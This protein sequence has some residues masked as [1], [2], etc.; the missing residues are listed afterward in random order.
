MNK[1]FVLLTMILTGI[2]LALAGCGGGGGGSAA[3]ATLSTGN[4]SLV[5]TATV[6]GMIQLPGQT[7]HGNIVVTLSR[8]EGAQVAAIAR[9]ISGEIAADPQ[10]LASPNRDLGIYAGVTD[11]AGRYSIPGVPE[12]DYLLSAKKG[13]AYVGGQKSLSVSALLS[14]VDAGTVLL[15][16]TGSI[17]G[18]VAFNPP[19]ANMAGVLC[20]IEGTSFL[21]VT[22]ATGKYTISSVPLLDA[23]Y[24]IGFSKTGFVPATIGPVA[25]PTSA[26][27]D[28]VTAPTVTLGFTAFQSGAGNV[29]V[30]VAGGQ[31]YLQSAQLTFNLAVA[32]GVEAPIYMIWSQQ[33]YLS[34]A[35]GRAPER[36]A[37]STEP[38]AATKTFTLPAEG[39]YTFYLMLIYADGRQ[40]NLTIPNQIYYDRTAPVLSPV[41]YGPSQPN[42]SGGVPGALH[43]RAIQA[44]L[45]AYDYVSG[46]NAM[47]IS[48]D[49]FATGTYE[50]YA[51]YKGLTLPS[52]S[53]TT[54]IGI[55]V[56]DRAGNVASATLPAP[57][58]GLNRI[59]FGQSFI[60]LPRTTQTLDPANAPNGLDAIFD[61]GAIMANVTP[62]TLTV[63]RGTVSGTTYTP[64][65]TGDDTLEIGF[66]YDGRTV[67]AQLG[68]RFTG[69]QSLDLNTAASHP[70]KYGQT[71]DLATLVPN[72]ITV[73][74]SGNPI[75]RT[76]AQLTY[77]VAAADG[78]IAGTV[79]TP[80]K[81][82][83]PITVTAAF[84]ENGT[85]VTAT[86]TVAMFT[87]TA[88]TVATFPSPF[89]VDLNAPVDL[90][91]KFVVTASFTDG[92]TGVPVNPSLLTYASQRGYPLSGSTY[93]ANS[94]A[95]DVITVTLTDGVPVQSTVNVTVVTLTSVAPRIAD[96]TLFVDETIVLDPMATITFSDPARTRDEPLTV[97]PLR[98]TF[99][100]LRGEYTAPATAGTDT[101]TLTY[102]GPAGPVTSTV[103]VT[104]L[105]APQFALDVANNPILPVVTPTPPTAGFAMI[106]WNYD[107]PVRV[108]LVYDSK[109]HS[110]K[111]VDR[112]QFT[113]ESTAL[114]PAGNL[115]LFDLSDGTTYYY[116]LIADNGR[117][118]PVISDE[119]SFE[120]D[121]MQGLNPVTFIEDALDGAI[122]TSVPQNTPS[123]FMAFRIVTGLGEPVF[124]EEIVLE[125][126]G[127]L[128]FDYTQ[129]RNLRLEYPN[130]LPI[131]T[132]TWFEPGVV[133]K[134]HFVV[135]QKYFAG[136]QFQF[137]VRGQ[138]NGT[139]NS[140]KTLQFL[141]AS[142]LPAKGTGY[143]TGGTVTSNVQP[144]AAGRVLTI[145]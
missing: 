132:Q 11:H 97:V 38:F 108:T 112:Y 134:Y 16:P 107:Q 14:E 84:T 58:Y 12:G 98:G 30:T 113:D 34:T 78:A 68:I 19:S 128:G 59:S 114:K 33:N 3:T 93:T 37:G 17:T 6:S 25:L 32:T 39:R 125:A 55:R 27:G 41:L 20:F 86:F 46:L 1:A 40:E 26:V 119:Y 63:Q 83:G 77:T 103:T 35:P 22:D 115:S 92:R 8:Q 124:I 105:G 42:V 71:V 15:T 61:D 127:S 85:T 118:A 117:T 136:A 138:V 137:V 116:R 24:R 141:P 109:S 88:V 126:N 53:G 80:V 2:S 95:A 45:G 120:N 89:S 139:A 110:E 145:Q 91:E 69:L 106:A 121:Y 50:T 54:P 36:S 48:L 100:V 130:G 73:Y 31:T 72:P 51:A 49:N 144:A 87:L 57:Y 101:L 44:S 65:A 13:D 43:N 76:G 133:N 75:S 60:D 131:S 4:P 111:D 81:Q 96:F 143:T 66:T 52:A 62:Q 64:P 7:D 70:L 129:I 135:N 122:A 5:P 140:G 99:D 123:D 142:V 29:A 79:L 94:A 82:N 104:V 47:W 102:A 18:L 23:G 28:T 90:Q 74:T 56:A 67:T 9:M 10:A 21:A